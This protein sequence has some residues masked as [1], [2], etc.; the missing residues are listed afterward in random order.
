MIITLKAGDSISPVRPLSDSTIRRWTFGDQCDKLFG[1]LMPGARLEVV[2]ICK[3]PG[4][5]WVRA[6]ILGRDPAGYIKIAGEEF[7]H[8]FRR[9]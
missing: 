4:S 7:A 6:Q 3:T 8:N 2:E 9:A 1:G 5:M